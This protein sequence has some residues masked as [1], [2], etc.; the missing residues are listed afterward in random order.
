MHV[1]SLLMV[2][3]SQLPFLS[4]SSCLFCS[5]DSQTLLCRLSDYLS[6]VPIS[7]SLSLVFSSSLPIPIS[8]C[9]R[10]YQVPLIYT[11]FLDYHIHSMILFKTK[12]N[13]SVCT[14]L[15]HVSMGDPKEKW[16]TQS[17]G[18]V[19]WLKI[20]LQWKGTKC[21]KPWRRTVMGRLP[22]KA[23]LTRVRSYYIDWK[24]MCK[25]CVWGWTFVL[26][27]RKEKEGQLYKFM[28]CF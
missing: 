10:V 13:R 2:T 5:L 24:W 25:S 12:M 26:H 7:E 18:L 4:F 6:K 8:E 14:C 23:Q 17:S 27:G 19:L 28:F 21:K 16:L 3:S 20:Q 11:K 1:N 9:P 22:E 15:P